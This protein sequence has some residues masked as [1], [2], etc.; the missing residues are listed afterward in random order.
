[1]AQIKVP[2]VW[3]HGR[4]DGWMSLERVQ[5]LMSCGASENRRLLEVP[6]GHQLRTSGEAL[7]AFQLVAQE[8]SEVLLGRRLTPMLPNLADLERRRVAERA[9]RPRADINLRT[10]WHDYLLGRDET[11]G[12]ELMGATSLYRQFLD[13]QI[14]ALQL[15]TPAKVLDLGAGTGE[16]TVRLAERGIPGC[17]VTALDLVQPALQRARKRIENVTNAPNL[18]CL[19]ADVGRPGDAAIPFRGAQ[20][21]A[22]LA[23]LLIGYLDEPLPLLRQIRELL[24]EGGRVVVSAP[25][26]DADISKLFSDTVGERFLDNLSQRFGESVLANFEAHQAEFLN[27][28]AKVLELEDDGRFRFYDPGEL[29]DLLR[30]AGFRGTESHVSFGTPGQF[31]IAA[32]IR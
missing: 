25:R 1:M 21:D 17:H 8:A 16:L 7:D 13:D 30:S 27:N 12:M 26:R 11:V 6:T 19:V 23:S 20:F 5:E 28:A 31:A 32:G 15:P 3:I 29:E 22:A 10:F 24:R 18:T 9:R 14:S 4:H 2:V